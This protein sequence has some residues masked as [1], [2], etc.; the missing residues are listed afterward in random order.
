[1]NLT[2]VIVQALGGLGIFLLGMKLMSEGLQKVAGDRLRSF[3]EAVSSNRVVGC[4]VGAG[5]TAAVQSSSATTV[6]V[7]GFVNA[8]LMNLTQ[9]VGVVLGANVGTTITAQ[10][11]AFKI[12][13][14]ALPAIAIGVALKFFSKRRKW[15]FVGEVI[16]GFGLLFYGM[17]VMKAGFKPL[18]SHPEFIAFFTRFDASTIWGILLCVLTGAVLTI[19]V[20]S[21][22]ATIGIT[23]ALA[24]EGLLNLP[25]SIALI[26]GENIGT[27][28]T[29]ELA[30]I[31]G[32]VTSERAARAHT[33]FNV[34]GVGYIII[35]FQP[36][37]SFVEWVTATFLG[38][39]PP[40]A[41]VDG[42]KPNINR[43]IA[44]AH[45]MFN[46]INAM[47]FLVALPLL[48]KAAVFLTRGR[49]EDIVV[50]DL[51]KPLHL[52]KKFT[53]NPSVALVEAREET[54]RM[55]RMA[56][57]AYRDVSEVLFNRKLEELDRLKPT[58][59]A[60]DRLQRSITEY[61]V[62]VS[63]GSITEAESREIASLIRMVN[64]I[65]RV[66][67]AVENLAELSEEMVENKLQLAERGDEVFNDHRFLG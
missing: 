40:E 14:L 36:F 6:M 12:T 55:G 56:Q 11:I 23:M 49:H 53:D 67:D 8:G 2:A 50:A 32:T 41:L 66:G 35:L 25:G 58:E 19:L 16:L 65:E 54:V 48:V 4:L 15:K 37:V 46:V 9:A 27:T 29:A 45:T 17:S 57:L 3:L 42:N 31:G 26:L 64:N 28:I 52:D 47:V 63:Q 62:E 13:D 39:G 34:I 43:Y 30:A 44:N 51:G 61:L 5:V 1:M 18:R 20:Q 10:L 7:V 38:S 21:S 22:S 24:S 59:E 60:L 33:M